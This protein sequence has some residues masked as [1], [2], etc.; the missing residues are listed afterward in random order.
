MFWSILKKDLKRKKTMNVILLL[1]LILSAMFASASVNNIIAVTGGIENYFDEAGVPDALVFINSENDAEEKIRA[2]STVSEVKTEHALVAFS[3]KYFKLNGKKLDNFINPAI[4]LS[5]EEMAINYFDE[6]NNII[7]S[8]DKGCFYANSPFLQKLDIK[9]GDEVELA[10]GDSSVKLKYMGRFKGALLSY[11][12]TANPYLIINSE[13]YDYLDKDDVFHREDYKSLYVSTTDVDSLKTLAKDYDG[14]YVN[15][16]EEMKNIYLYDMIAAYIMMTISILL[17]VTAFVML[18]FTI[19]FTISEEFREIGVMKAV[20][21]DNGSIRRLYIIKYLAIAVVGTII[22]YFCS[23]PLGNMMMKTISDNMVLSG[24]SS[25][26]MGIISSEAVVVIIL[27]FCYTCTRQVKKLSPIDAVRSGQTGE[28]FKKKSLLHL[29]RSKLPATGFM[30]LNDVVSAPRRFSI[31]TLIFALCMLLITTMS[32]FA[33]TLRSGKILWLFDIPTSDAHILDSELISEVFVDQSS[34]KHIID[35]TEKLLADNGMPGR[36]TMTLTTSCETRHDDKK[37]KILFT[38][39]KGDT[40]DEL[41]VDEGYAPRKVNEIAVTK[42]TLDDFGVQIGDTLTASIGEKDY[43]FIIT[44]TYSSFQSHAAH[45]YK[46]FDMG[47]LS[48]N[49]TTGVNINFDG[50]PD[51]KTIDQNVEK[52]K[53]LIE[54]D[55]VNNTS[56]MI[57]TMTGISGTL[58]TIKKMMMILTI[59]ITALIVVLMERSFISKEKGEIALMKAVGIPNGSIIAQHVI[60]FAIVSVLA[61]FISLAVLS[62]ISNSM[63][64]WVCTMI[65]DVSGI[66]CAYDPIEIFVIAPAILIGTAVIG[67]FLTALY[68]KTIKSSDTASI[69]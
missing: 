55:K 23:I 17:M 51:Q 36:C 8:V 69:E 47:S 42:S 20:G 5:D 13:D 31:I 52:L 56:D 66:K 44:G 28:R 49:G 60:R 19:G 29:G 59:I 68:T 3:S 67:S 40:D 33:L 61:C 62:P 34:Y 7:K 45:L 2:L 37:A 46:D 24:K 30:A 18:R 4:L 26:L 6:D 9:E 57:N 22:G 58:D 54:S 39:I 32:N 64:N 43:E 35:D 53:D 48:A 1:F 38:I 21:I 10:A 50:D 14:V 27:L 25:N 65:G 63:M 16:R 12:N 15:T 41:R 11:D